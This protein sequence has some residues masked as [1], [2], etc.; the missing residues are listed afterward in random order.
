[1]AKKTIKKFKV[2]I[3]CEMQFQVGE[4][5]TDKEFARDSDF[6]ELCETIASDRLKYNAEDINLRSIEEITEKEEDNA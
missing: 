4:R 3:E 5:D 1:M 6:G 2:I